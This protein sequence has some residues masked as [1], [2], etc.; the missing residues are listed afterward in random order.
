MRIIV[1]EYNM[2]APGS[3]L[4]SVVTTGLLSCGF[5]SLVSRA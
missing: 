2:T 3:F 5:R 4:H 1:G